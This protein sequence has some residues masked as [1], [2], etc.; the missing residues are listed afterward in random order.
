VQASVEIQ[1]ID[2]WRKVLATT[3]ETHKHTSVQASVEIQV[4]DAW[5]NV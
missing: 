2:V 4:I 3:E 5:R 1:V